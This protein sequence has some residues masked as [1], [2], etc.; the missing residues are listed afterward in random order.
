MDVVI[1]FAQGHRIVSTY[2]I[3]K[4][5]RNTTANDILA[6]FKD[7]IK[8]LNPSR[9]LQISMD[10]SSTNLVS[11]SKKNSPSVNFI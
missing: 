2:L 11:E 9:M 10:G 4:F 5:M 1:R 7:A 8:D 3:S 6:A